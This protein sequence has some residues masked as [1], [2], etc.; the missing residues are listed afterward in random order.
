MR[1]TQHSQ[2]M[3][4]HQISKTA[5]C[6]SNGPPTAG[7][8]SCSAVCCGALR[9]TQR[10]GGRRPL[11]GS[12]TGALGGP[13]VWWWGAACRHA[14]ETLASRHIGLVGS[15]EGSNIMNG[16]EGAI[17]WVA[18][19]VQKDQLGHPGGTERS[20]RSPWDVKQDTNLLQQRG[21]NAQGKQEALNGNCGRIRFNPNVRV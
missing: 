19:G 2:Y 13:P 1:I 3:F 5:K 12:G 4:V 20:T 6:P 21:M 9:G 17:K 10:C 7:W 16:S 8:N 15:V 14:T 18:P 11:G